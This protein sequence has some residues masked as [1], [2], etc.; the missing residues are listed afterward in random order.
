MAN[1][2]NTIDKYCHNSG[3]LL[4]FQRSNVVAVGLPPHWQAGDTA[5]L[6]LLQAM[7][8]YA[9]ARRDIG[10][11]IAA[12]NRLPDGFFFKFWGKS[13][14]THKLPPMLKG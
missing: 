13:P 14:G 6:H 10:N 12:L 11:A 2:V 1:F 5:Y 3:A 8:R 7:G 4:P 9:Q